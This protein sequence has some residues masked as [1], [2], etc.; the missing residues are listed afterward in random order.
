[1]YRRRDWLFGPSRFEADKICPF[2]WPTD[3][4]RGASNP[5]GPKARAFTCVR[6]C[7]II[8]FPVFSLGFRV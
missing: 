3:L 8:F 4:I 5:E 1:M 2:T 6:K 7:L